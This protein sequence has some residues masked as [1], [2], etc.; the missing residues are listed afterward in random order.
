[1]EGIGVFLICFTCGFA[2]EWNMHGDLDFA[3]AVLANPFVLIIAIFVGADISGAQYNPAVS[4]TL[5]WLRMQDTSKTIRYII[6][7]L[8]GSMMAGVTLLALKPGRFETTVTRANQLGHCAL[9]DDVSQLQG[10]WI[11]IIATG[12]LTFCAFHTTVRKLSPFESALTMAALVGCNNFAFAQS[13][14]CC[15]NPARVFGPSVF[16]GRF[17]QRGFWIYYLGDILGGLAGGLLYVRVFSHREPSK[18][19][20]GQ[21]E[22]TQAIEMH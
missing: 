9:A 18:C 13:T 17:F 11:E 21:K 19:E 20:E 5:W 15:M 16:S 22:Q 7:Q 6:A 4:V 1:M 14:G 10:L 2:A 3:G 12:L 8:I